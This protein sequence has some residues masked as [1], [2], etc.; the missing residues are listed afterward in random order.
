MFRCRT[1]SLSRQLS[2]PQSSAY[3]RT[4]AV[5]NVVLPAF[6]SDAFP[7]FAPSNRPRF[8]RRGMQSRAFMSSIV[9]VPPVAGRAAAG[10]DSQWLESLTWEF[11]YLDGELGHYRAT[12][13]GGDE[14]W[15]I[16]RPA[17]LAADN[18]L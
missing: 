4:V 3:D 10:F 6:G 17:S 5:D 7:S 9:N 1:T 18:A 2:L 8:G 13:P 11:L 12:R 15:R 14:T 16:V